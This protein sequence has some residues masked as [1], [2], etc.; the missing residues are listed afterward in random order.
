MRTEQEYKNLEEAKDATIAQQ[1]EQLAA[2]TLALEN[3]E[4]RHVFEAP[5]GMCFMPENTP[6]QLA[7]LAEQCDKVTK[8]LSYCVAQIPEF[9]SVPGIAEALALP[10][11]AT[12]ALNRIEARG[13]LKAAEICE[14]ISDEY[15]DR[16]GAKYPELKTDAE[17]GASDCESAIR[18]RAAELEGVKS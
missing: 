14:R 1:A 2:L 5:E 12:P 18:A 13:M 17:T 10:D 11:I 16:E 15:H 9:A 7:A 3:S 4:N 8:S 6:E